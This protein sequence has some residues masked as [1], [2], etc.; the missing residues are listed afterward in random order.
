MLINKKIMIT[1]FLTFLF[2]C[3]GFIFPK[4]VKASE[5]D[6]NLSYRYNST[7]NA[8]TVI[9]TSSNGFK[10]T[11]PTWSLSQDK[12]TYRKT[13][14]TN[15]NYYTK[16]VLSNG[17]ET[18]I[19]LNVTQVDDRGPVISMRYT[20]DSTNDSVTA[21]MSSNEELSNTKPTWKLSSDKLTYTKKYYNN[22]SYYTDVKD[23]YGNNTRVKLNITQVKGPQVTMS[24][25]YN[26]ETNTITAK[27]NSNKPMANTKPTWTLSSDKL[28][29]TKKYY[30]NQSYYTDVKDECGNNTRVKLNITQIK[31]PEIKINYI[32]NE[33]TNT[34]TATMKSNRI[35]AD[36]KPTWTLTSDKLTY[37]KKFD[38]NQTYTTPVQDTYGNVTNVKIT[39]TQI[40]NK[41]KNG[42]DV[43]LYQGTIDWTKVKKSGIEFAMIRAGYRGYGQA[44]TL[45]E[46]S[47][48]SKNVLGATSNGIDVGIYFYTQ[49][50]NETEAKEEAKF[51]LN[52]IKKYG[53]KVTYPI[54][55]DTEL[56][57][58]GTGRADNISVSKRT[59]VVKAFCE[60]ILSAGYTPMIYA[61][62][63]WLNDNL[64][65]SKLSKYDVWLAHYTKQTDYKGKY[66]MWQYTSKGSVNGING[67]V[68]KNYCYKKYN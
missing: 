41:I 23:K 52:L 24:Y 33:K 34:V 57:P 26:E 40:Q 18:N 3:F 22:Q 13:Y 65:M 17:T 5:D 28:T 36:T 42:I 58:P 12:Q 51:V 44:G 59:A 29:Y 46:D 49:A 31:G 8:V 39:I 6:V 16:F 25:I 38:S 61:N 30:N 56:S 54:A 19:R 68:D 4:I 21:I 11:K 67:N 10:N 37:I 63:Y 2:I 20:Y 43:S 66:T 14:F 62:K 60:T 7:S 48:F 1:I 47:M 32:Y 55:I 35:L 64:D 27:I 45:V 53:I 15:E 50:I 9:A